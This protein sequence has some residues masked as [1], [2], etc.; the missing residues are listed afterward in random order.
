MDIKYQLPSP[1]LWGEGEDEASTSSTFK[2]IADRKPASY[3]AM[4]IIEKSFL[5]I[6]SLPEKGNLSV[7]G[8]LTVFQLNCGIAA[9]Q[10]NSG[11][12]G[13]NRLRRPPVQQ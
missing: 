9:G 2:K 4:M 8:S 12:V 7:P 11:L 3:P 5:W 6:D 1:V 10:I 13:S